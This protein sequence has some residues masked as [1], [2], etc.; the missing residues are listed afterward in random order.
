MG[1]AF[2]VA[3][4]GGVLIFSMY[5]HFTNGILTQGNLAID[6]QTRQDIIIVLEDQLGKAKTIE[7]EEEKVISQLPEKVQQ[8][9]D[10][11]LPSVLINAQKTTLTVVFDF[12]LFS[13]FFSA[14]LPKT[15]LNK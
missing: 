12:L 10:S 14:F 8:S 3:V 15:K 7:E 2:G 1:I 5:S 4:I 9:I 11:F 13:L 6:E